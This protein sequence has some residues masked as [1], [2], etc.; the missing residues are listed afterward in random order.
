MIIGFLEL[1]YINNSHTPF[2][3]GNGDFIKEDTME[4]YI[5]Y[6]TAPY[7]EYGKTNNI[8]NAAN[9]VNAIKRL[10]GVEAYVSR[11]E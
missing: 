1:T 11:V 8:D 3:K 6:S 9:A 5:V 10:Y 2:S 7:K 4:T